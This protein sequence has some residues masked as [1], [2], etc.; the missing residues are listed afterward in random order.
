M[1]QVNKQEELI[2]SG[3]CISAPTKIPFLLELNCFFFSFWFHK[4]FLFTKQWMQHN[5]KRT[6]KPYISIPA[7]KYEKNQ[8]ENSNKLN[9]LL[10]SKKKF[11]AKKGR[12]QRWR[13]RMKKTN[14]KTLLNDSYIFELNL[15]KVL[16][17]IIHIHNTY[18]S[19]SS[20]Y[21]IIFEMVLR[22]INARKSGESF[23]SIRF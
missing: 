20:K 11:Q 12:I 22:N 18:T 19:T 23:P 8:K 9:A 6:Y 13:E 16:Y 10:E 15:W 5:A 7:K 4:H 1:K 3:L 2:L 21:C 17:T 14:Y